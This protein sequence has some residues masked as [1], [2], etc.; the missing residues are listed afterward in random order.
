M[1]TSA[2]SL[3]FDRLGQGPP[4]VLVHPL[5]ADRRVWEPVL[6]ALS[7]H[8]DVLAVDMPGFGASRELEGEV[9]ATPEAIAGTIC[10]TLDAL[11]L[12]NA[13]MAGIS[14][15][16]WV[17]LEVGKSGR[18]LSVTGIN[19]AGLWA[20]PLGPRP[21]VARRAARRL[22]PL[23]RA[24]LRS[25]G[26]RRAALSGT[27]AHPERVPPAAAYELLRAYALSPGFERAN[28][29]MRRTVF[30]GIEKLP[31]P[32]TLA[33]SE[34][35]RLVGRPG[36]EIPGVRAITLTDCG[37]VP[38]WDSPEQVAEAILSTTRAVRSRVAGAP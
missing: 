3:A 36:R 9:C 8:H 31:V 27:V 30:T 2:P 28:V 20:S 15:G 19:P 32:V 11:G 7:T 26:G 5:G 1:V 21:E 24:L 18:A 4:L 13:H 10:A 33:W 37:H 16:G 6:E 22:L 14:L 25:E 29:E 35:D 17:A 12:E 34:H 38:T 23:A